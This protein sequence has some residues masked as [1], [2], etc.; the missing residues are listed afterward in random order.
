VRRYRRKDHPVRRHAAVP[1]SKH[2]VGELALGV[3]L[4]ELVLLAGVEDVDVDLGRLFRHNRFGLLLAA[5]GRGVGG[6]CGGALASG[7]G[8]A[9]GG[10]G[11]ARVGRAKERAARIVEGPA[12]ANASAMGASERSAPAVAPARPSPQRQPTAPHPVP[13]RAPHTG[14]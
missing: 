2:D 4:V 11:M 7:G 13:G 8:L 5:G 9:L 14:G 12:T 10:G 1:D 6:G 3:E